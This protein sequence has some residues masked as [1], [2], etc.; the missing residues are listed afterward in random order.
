MNGSAMAQWKRKPNVPGERQVIPSATIIGSAEQVRAGSVLIKPG[1]A[2]PQGLVLSLRR[3]GQWNLI[4]DLPAT[5]LDRTLRRKGWHCFYIVPP[6]E[7]S[8]VG[9]SFHSAFRK[10]LAGVVRQ[11]DIQGLNT[12]EIAD[13]RV[14]RFLGLRYVVVTAYPRHIRNSPYLRDPDPH[15]YV[16]GMWDFKRIFDTQNRRQP[17]VKA[18]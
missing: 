7:A 18:M 13:V 1:T 10:A 8:G 14:R 15:H 16:R 12:T 11:I 2:L 6:I 17:Q 4:A 9:L 5:E 3:A